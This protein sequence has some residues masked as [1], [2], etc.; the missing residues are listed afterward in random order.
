MTAEV[1][2]LFRC[3]SCGEPGIQVTLAKQ[4]DPSMSMTLVTCDKCCARHMAA[5]DK[6]RPVFKTMKEVGVPDDIANDVMQRL[7]D[8]WPDP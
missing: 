2:P 7:L 3:G 8:Q 6:V 1:V 4:D 5:L